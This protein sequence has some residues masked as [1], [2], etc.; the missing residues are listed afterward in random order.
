MRRP[1]VVECAEFVLGD[2]TLV[3]GG[4]DL[5]PAE[6]DPTQH[7]RRIP[8]AIEA[9]TIVDRRVAAGKNNDLGGLG[10]MV[11]GGSLD[12]EDRMVSPYSGLHDVGQ[13]ILFV[14]HVVVVLKRSD[15]RDDVK[16]EEGVPPDPAAVY[17]GDVVVVPL[18]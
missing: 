18:V 2:I 8:R 7:Q 3:F 15:L 9:H 11:A 14:R 10:V 16:P 5:L 12:K 13:R 4:D 17:G 1:A 6:D